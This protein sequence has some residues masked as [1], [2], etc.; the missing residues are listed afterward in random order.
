MKAAGQMLKEDLWK[1]Y[2]KVYKQEGEFESFK[3]AERGMYIA[4]AEREKLRD[5]MVEVIRSV[6]IPHIEKKFKSLSSHINPKKRSIF[7]GKEAA[8]AIP[9]D[10][11]VSACC[12]KRK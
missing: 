11:K 5:M 12:A 6:I 3:N 9:V 2:V 4:K 10:S 1:R 8:S 7:F